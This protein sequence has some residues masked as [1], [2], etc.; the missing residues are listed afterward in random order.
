[1]AEKEIELLCIG[2]AI[3]DVFARGDEALALRY[4]IIDPVQHIEYENLRE[5]I[6]ALPQQSALSGGGAAN[7]A[8]IAGFLGVD[9]CFIGAVGADSNT[10]DH[11][12]SADSGHPSDGLGRLFE[13][14]LAA[15]GVQA[16]LFRRKLPTGIC[17]M[18]ELPG[19]PTRIAAAPSAA[20]ELT[21]ED[22]DEAAIRKAKV[23][24]LDG[25]MMDRQDL[26]RRILD[27][28]N[29]NGTAVALDV[30]SA[31]L[32]G[33]RALELATYSRLYPLILFMNEAE[34][35]AFYQ[36]ISKQDS[37]NPAV[38]K[39][40][41]PEILNEEMYGFFKGFTA[42]ELFP[43]V[44]V[45]L[46]KR[47]AVVFAGGAIHK[48]ETRPIIPVDTTGAGDAFCGAFLSAWVRSKSLSECA[49]L[50]N[51]VAREVLHVKGT[52]INGKKLRGF[53]KLLR[54]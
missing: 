40:D 53:A 20:L 29:R 4:G 14:D 25:F 17:L 35:R 24:I 2:N 52:G 46:G 34:A 41:D 10:A 9:T 50:G 38:D 3:V 11:S 39:D 51:K 1:M 12:D 37:L 19:G 49:S 30:S 13:E 48:E 54:K 47:G 33:T 43:I 22:I 36:V 21:A 7:A 42:N 32:A 44:A 26:V 16:C 31:H 8:K 45:K 5:L 27:M 6:A 28:A 18:L 15:A 23:V